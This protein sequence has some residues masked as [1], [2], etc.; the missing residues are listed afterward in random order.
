MQDVETQIFSMSGC[1]DYKELK[2]KCDTGAYSYKKSE[3]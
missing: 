1:D 3:P 2:K